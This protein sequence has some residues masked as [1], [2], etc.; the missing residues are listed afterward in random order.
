MLFA[1]QLTS[2]PVVEM[3]RSASEHCKLS[4]KLALVAKHIHPKPASA[5]VLC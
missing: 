1:K 3:H 4:L 5:N 2:D